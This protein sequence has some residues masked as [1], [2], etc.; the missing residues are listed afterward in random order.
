VNDILWLV[1]I[2]LINAYE[3][4]HLAFEQTVTKVS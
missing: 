1:N 4:K 3:V 2:K